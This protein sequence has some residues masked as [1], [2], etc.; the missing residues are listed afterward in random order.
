M[1][2]RGEEYSGEEYS[3]EEYSGEEYSGEEYSGEEY[4]GEE[5]SGNGIM[6]RLDSPIKT[7]EGSVRWWCW[8]RGL[9]VRVT[10]GRPF[11]HP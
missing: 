1:K 3:G 7:V 11:S 9:D 4:S 6:R 8:T 2:R 5:Y 10:H